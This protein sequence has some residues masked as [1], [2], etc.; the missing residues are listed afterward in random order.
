MRFRLRTLVILTAVGPPV[1]AG[2]WLFW[3]I[4]WRILIVFAIPIVY[5]GA[6]VV[7]GMAIVI[8]MIVAVQLASDLRRLLTKGRNSDN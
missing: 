4:T 7:L 5:A 6:I 8:P 2:A 3:D 1:L